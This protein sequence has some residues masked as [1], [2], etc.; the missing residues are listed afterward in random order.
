[1]DVLDAVDCNW[2]LST[3]QNAP[4]IYQTFNNYKVSGSGIY[5]VEIHHKSY[6]AGTGNNSTIIYAI[7]RAADNYWLGQNYL[8]N[9]DYWNI[10][11]ILNDVW[12][13]SWSNDWS[14]RSFPGWARLYVN[15]GTKTI[16]L[17]ENGGYLP[18]RWVGIAFS[19]EGNV[20]WSSDI[21]LRDA[22]DVL[23][24]FPVEQLKFRVITKNYTGQHSAQA[25]FDDL[26]VYEWEDDDVVL[27]HDDGRDAALGDAAT[28]SI[29][30]DK[31]FRF[32]SGTQE[33]HQDDKGKLNELSLEDAHSLRL[34]A[35]TLPQQVQPSVLP[36]QGALVL[37]ESAVTEGDRSQIPQQVGFDDGGNAA[38]RIQGQ[39][40]FRQDTLDPEAHPHFEGLKPLAMFY[41]RTDGEPWANPTLTNFSGFAKDGTKYTNGVQDIGPVQAPWAQEF[42][43]GNR[44]ARDD[45]PDE[46]LIVVTQEEVVLFDLDNWPTTMGMWMR[47]EID[48]TGAT[49]GMMGRYSE[50][51]QDVAMRNGV[52]VACSRYNTVENGRLHIVDFRQ[53]GTQDCAHLIEATEHWKWGASYDIRNRNENRWT[54]SGVSP[55][56]RIDSEYNYSV[57]IFDNGQGKAWVAITGEDYDPHVIG[58]EDN[59]PPQWSSRAHG[60]IDER[61][62]ANA[63]D[64]RRVLFDET[65]WLWF[66]IENRLYR[67]VFDYQGGI[68]IYDQ[69]RSQRGAVFPGMRITALAQGR[70]YVYV[71][72][73]R[74]VY[75]V[76]KGSLQANLAYTI[77]GG[78]GGG[79]LDNPPDGEVI[80]GDSPYVVKLHCISTDKSSILQIVT[81]TTTGLVGSVTTIRLTDDFIIGSRKYPD[82]PED[83]V[84]AGASTVGV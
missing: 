28:Y 4:N 70:N 55:E 71:G 20:D 81:R 66:S 13:D 48:P 84:F 15:L 45:F 80:V 58:L 60:P 40:Q 3:E 35:P 44:S 77:A 69:G 22:S 24:G 2:W 73:D 38:W 36:H 76:H 19:K 14:G 51:I 64:L 41:Y 18:P 68:M 31:D 8:N 1:M 17:P 61:G 37:G 49:Y 30:E 11:R 34:G 52:L 65:G 25:K 33:P 7:E 56:L 9:S 72:T 42:T 26:Y 10:G 82:L 23:D 46:V 50:Y 16:R 47:F 74:G 57:D 27:E 59:K 21:F 79:L 5:M 54:T 53:D 78:G 6:V 83:E 32:A 63:G 29:G 43:S 12:T 39:V 75:R 67:S 62:Q